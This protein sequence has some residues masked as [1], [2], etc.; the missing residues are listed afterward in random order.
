[1]FKTLEYGVGHFKKKFVLRPYTTKQ[2]LDILIACTLN[3][4]PNPY[5]ILTNLNGCIS[6]SEDLQNLNGDEVKLLLLSLRSISV[7]ESVEHKGKCPHCG[8]PYDTELALDDLFELENDSGEIILNGVKF[9]IKDDEIF[10]IEAK[11]N[12]N[13]IG[14]INSKDKTII[15]DVIDNLSFE[16]YDQLLEFIKSSKMKFKFFNLIHC[17]FCSGE[18]LINMSKNSYILDILSEDTLVSLFKSVADMVHFGKYTKEDI[19]KMY[20]FERNIYR[21]LLEAQLQEYKQTNPK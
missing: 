11:S 19:Y 5:E 9:Y 7:G 1:M 8:K 20:P 18:I 15:Q 17:L 21:G 14:L 3:E 13:G 16:D 6:T 2:E 4:E 10:K 12:L